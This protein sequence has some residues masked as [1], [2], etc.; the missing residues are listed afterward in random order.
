[1][2]SDRRVQRA[3]RHALDLA[4]VGSRGKRRPSRLRSQESGGNRPS[5]GSPIRADS[6]AAHVAR[7]AQVG[8]SHPQERRPALPGVAGTRQAR[9]A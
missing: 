1:M 4:D 8:P 7:G 6:Q 9:V 5:R 3:H 2:G